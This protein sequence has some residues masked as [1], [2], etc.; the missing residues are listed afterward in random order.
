MTPLRCAA[1]IGPVEMVQ[2]L[3]EA[4]ARWTEIHGVYHY[5]TLLAQRS[6][7][8]LWLRWRRADEAAALLQS[9][10]EGLETERADDRLETRQKRP[11]LVLKLSELA[12]V[13]VGG[14]EEEPRRSV[15]W[16]ESALEII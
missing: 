7:A 3:L 16:L 5:R 11:N 4:G 13:S 2:L 10:L 6:L 14:S 12:E 9:L 8:S 15:P 1:F